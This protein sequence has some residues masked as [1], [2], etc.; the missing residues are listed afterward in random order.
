[1]NKIPGL[2]FYA[3]D[4]ET[5]NFNKNSAC[6]IGIVRFI[7]GVEENSADSLIKTPDSYFVKE[8]TDQIH[9]ITYENV[10]DKPKFPAVWK[11]II[12]PFIDENPKLP[13]VAHNAGF[14]MSVIKYTNLYYQIQFPHLHY[15]DSLAISRKVWPELKSHRLTSLAENFGINYLAHN[16][17]E[18][19]RTCGILVNLASE[20]VQA[21][22]V[23]DLLKKLKIQMK[24]LR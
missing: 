23:H 3:V 6:S 11:N 14:D 7:D 9:H 4:F 17:L 21:K 2:D 12:G 22:S 19:A 8:W 15:F 10:A 13:F 5:A 24:I 1:M 18:D 16:A 20:C